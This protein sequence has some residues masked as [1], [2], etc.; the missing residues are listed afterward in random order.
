M[1]VPLVVLAFFS[2]VV[3]WPFHW[4]LLN[5][6]NSQLEHT[7]HHAQP[8]AVQVQFGLG[9][10][11]EVVGKLGDTREFAH[12]YHTLAG[13]LATAVVLIAIIFAAV[14]YWRP[15]QML[16][17]AE[18]REQFARVHAFLANKWYFDELYSAIIVRP[19]LVVAQWARAFDAR[20]IDGFVDGLGRFGV[21]LSRWDG[22]FDAR[23]IDGLVNVLADACQALGARL[24]GV[25]TG[26]LRSY[27]LFLALAAVGTFLVLAYFVTRVAAG[28]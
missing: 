15:V 17:P 27:V 3:A 2:V 23:I 6:E 14:V 10:G 24:R 16:D 11:E 8:I 7:I 4:N 1:T 25:Q 5:A 22:L 12:Q 19:G 21:I 26:Y 9:P 18:A 13:L 20:V 28:P